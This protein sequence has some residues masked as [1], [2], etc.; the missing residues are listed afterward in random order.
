MEQEQILYKLELDDSQLEAQLN[1]TTQSLIQS[2]KAVKNLNNSLKATETEIAKLDKELA[3]NGKLTAE[4][5]TRLQ[6]LRAQQVQQTQA[7]VTQRSESSRLRAEQNNLIKNYTS[8]EGSNNKLRAELSLATAQYNAL[9]REQRLNS[10]EGLQLKARVKELSDELKANESAVGDNRRNVG[11]YTQSIRE[12]IVGNTALGKSVQGFNTALKANPLVL[13]ISL[14]ATFGQSVAKAQFIVDAF[15]RVVEPLNSLLQRT[16]GLVQGAISALRDGTFSFANFGKQAKEAF[17]GAIAEGRRLS[18]LR[19]E[20]EN[21]QNQFL[22]TEGKI[23]REFEAQ[24]SIVQDVN[25]SAEERRKAAELA[26]A[27]IAQERDERLGILALQIEEAKI[28]ASQND[29]DRKA[30][31]ELNR[32]LA[33]QDGLQA[34][35]LARTNEVRNQINALTK[36][37]ADANKAAAKANEEARK[38][39]EADNI[40]SLRKQ[41]EEADKLAQQQ[42]DAFA[43]LSQA[44]LNASLQVIDRT[45]KEQLDQLR[46]LQAQGLVSEQE[47]AEQSTIIQSNKIQRQIQEVQDYAGTVVGTEELIAQKQLE[48]SDLVTETRIADFKRIYDEQ[49][50]QADEALKQEQARQQA[51]QQAVNAQLQ[52]IAQA[53]SQLAK[54]IVDDNTAVFEK[55]SKAIL[56]TTLDVIERTIIAQQAAAIFQATSG[57]VAKFGIAGLITAGLKIA[58]ISSAFGLAKAGINKALQFNE[59]GRVPSGYEMQGRTRGGDNTLALL[60]PGE[61]VANKSQQSRIEAIAGPDIWARAGVPGFN[62]GGFIP[63]SPADIPAPRVDL[64]DANLTVSV[65]DIDSQLANVRVTNSRRTL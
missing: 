1:K 62:T 56:I 10:K 9:S 4:Q 41:A 30:Q 54:D 58:A 32:L 15:N 35:F 36:A 22:L 31:A 21:R 17:S 34:D 16:I 53:S 18:D 40:A 46:L 3:E 20:I 25:K 14:F 7:L 44:E 23:R 59:G 5:A 6:E 52:G 8:L 29:T 39:Q 42:A 43:K 65:R 24:R 55:F 33:E 50:R 64:T 2:D 48:L 60:K 63:P 47:F 12:A 11:N 49:K 13:V 26:V 45:A 61:V 27:A 19:I 51:F 57:D 37:Q 28:R 38:K